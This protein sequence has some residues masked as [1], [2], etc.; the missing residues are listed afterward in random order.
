MLRSKD[1]LSPEQW[2]IVVSILFANLPPSITQ[3]KPSPFL[4]LV[5]NQ[6]Q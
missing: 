5:I 4:I 6:D 2:G 3:R 1:I